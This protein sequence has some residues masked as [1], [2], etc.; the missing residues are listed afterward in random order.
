MFRLLR[1]TWRLHQT[2]DDN[3]L[4][5]KHDCASFLFPV[6]ISTFH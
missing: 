4:S 3:D 5:S 2:D 1:G 6:E